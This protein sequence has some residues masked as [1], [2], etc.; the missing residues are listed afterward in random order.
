MVYG[1]ASILGLGVVLMQRGHMFCLLWRINFGFGCCTYAI[2]AWIFLYADTNYLLWQFRC[3]SLLIKSSFPCPKE[4][5]CTR[6]TLRLRASQQRDFPCYSY[7][8]GRCLITITEVSV[9]LHF[10]QDRTS[11]EGVLMILLSRKITTRNGTYTD[12]NCRLYRFQ[13]SSL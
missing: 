11:C 13:K 8:I 6:F 9:S 3:N 10:V 7:I 1:D 12:E 5:P 2:R 4:A